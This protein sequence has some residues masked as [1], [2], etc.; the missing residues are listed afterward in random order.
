[1]VR[2]IRAALLSLLALPSL[3]DPLFESHEL[4]KVTLNAPLLTIDNERNRDRR[5]PGKFMVQVPSLTFNVDVMARGNKRRSRGTCAFPPLKIEFDR[6]ETQDTLFHKQSELKLV[7]Q[8]HPEH[9]KYEYYVITEYLIYRMFNELTDNSFRVRLMEVTYRD[10][11]TSLF[12]NL[13]FFI[14]R[15]RRLENRIDH[16]KLNLDSTNATQLDGEHL[17]LVSLFQMMI[18]NTDWSATHGGSDEC[19]HNGK[20]FGDEESDDNLYI[21]YDFDM[22]GLVNPEYA[23]I[24]EALE[25][26]SIRERR[27]RGYCRNLVYLEKNI[28]LL[29]EKRGAINSLIES[30][31]YLSGA[32]KR[33]RI[34][35]IDRFYRIINNEERVERNIENWCHKSTF[36]EVNAV[37]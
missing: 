20:L 3:A 26:D 9:L 36:I 30:T 22:T 5:Y 24:D 8:C 34:G 14:E 23:A 1:M 12:T 17:N 16:E 25:L 6:D 35:Y 7:T 33:Y 11:D 10:G 15:S 29:N 19:C 4:L 21:P 18:A 13:G 31:P 32:Q 27:F 28:A 2:L 37:Q